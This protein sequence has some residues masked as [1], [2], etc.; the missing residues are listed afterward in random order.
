MSP[1]AVVED[2]AVH[3][4]VIAG[5]LALVVI[6]AIW[7]STFALSKDLLTRMSVT[8]YLA[9]RF[10]TAAAVIG[11]ARPR[12]L[13]RRMDRR[14][15]LAGAALGV[16]YFSGQALQFFGL[17]HTAATVS[18]FVVSMYVVFT[19]LLS[20]ALLRS[21]PDRLILTATVLA[22]TG[23]ATMS[24]R[25]WS[26]GVGELLTLIAAVLYAGHILALSR[27]STGPTAYS[28]TFV[29]LL[30]MGVCFLLWAS[31]DGLHLPLRG[32]VLAFLYLSIVAGGVAM[33]VQ[34]WA[35]AH[36]ASGQA[37]VLMVLEPVWAAFFGFALWGDSLDVR[38]VVGAALVLVAMLLVVTRPSSSKTAT[39]G[40]A[41]VGGVGAVVKPDERA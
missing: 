10:L 27:W 4:R 39:V 21:R 40:A 34:T 12:W 2:H 24:L 19:P 38:T 31:V 18:A 20:A 16:C 22:T 32:D 29:Q 33:F 14:A 1:P 13:V 41:E 17:P 30:T 26:L 3:R 36:V 35:Q 7:G 23:I 15:L 25:G 9:L 11:L 6:T 28:L 37:A 5:A 8:D